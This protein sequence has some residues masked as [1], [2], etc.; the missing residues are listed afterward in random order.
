MRRTP[1]SCSRSS[2]KSAVSLPIESPSYLYRVPMKWSPRPLAS[3]RAS[4]S[5]QRAEERAQLFRQQLGCLERAEV[6]AARH[7]CPPPEI[8]VRALRPFAR[9][10]C[11]GEERDG[12]RNFD[13]LAGL[14]LESRGRSA[15]ELPFDVGTK[16]RRDRPR[17][18]V[19][20]QRC[21]ERVLIDAFAPLVPLVAD[22]RGEAGRRILERDRERLRPRPLNVRVRPGFFQPLRPCSEERTLHGRQRP[23]D[24]RLGEEAHVD[25]EQPPG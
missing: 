14:E 5:A 4:G 25:S 17:H 9:P 2:R 22:P 16:R 23:L 18:P 21:E 10:T 15:G 19:Q 3:K 1:F 20:R 24:V 13:A 6:T 12:G 7:L 11:N 8:R